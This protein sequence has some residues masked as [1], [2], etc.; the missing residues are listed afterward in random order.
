[1]K[2]YILYFYAAVFIY[3]SG[4]ADFQALFA[5]SNASEICRDK[6]AVR[7]QPCERVCETHTYITQ[8]RNKSEGSYGS[9]DHFKETG[10][11]GKFAETETLN[12]K[13]YNVYK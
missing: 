7:K 1:M 9:G 6:E 10:E 11:N 5:D 4:L 2:F 3:I 8:K 12:S 13:S